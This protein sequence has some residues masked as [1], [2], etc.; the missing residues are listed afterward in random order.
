[1]PELSAVWPWRNLF[2]STRPADARHSSGMI[3]RNRAS[4]YAVCEST[5]NVPSGFTYFRANAA[6]M[7]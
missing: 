3:S 1:M 2:A 7:F 6:L 5:V 4:I